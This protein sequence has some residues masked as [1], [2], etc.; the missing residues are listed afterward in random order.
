MP[1]LSTLDLRDATAD[2]AAALCRL[3]QR[4]YGQPRSME[5]WRWRYV[6]GPIGRTALV[7]AFA[8]DG[9]CLAA[10]CGTAVPFRLGDDTVV[11]ILHS[12][13]AVDPGV[14]LGRGRL[15][16]RMA[17]RFFD[18]FGGGDVAIAWGFPMPGLRRVLV[19]HNRC[20]VLQ[21]VHLVVRDVERA[22]QNRSASHGLCAERADPDVFTRHAPGLDALGQL[23]F[24]SPDIVGTRIDARWLQ[25]R[26]ARRPD[27]AYTPWIVRRAD[28]ITGLAITR[29]GGF[30]PDIVSLMEF[31]VAP[32]DH[33]SAAA[34]VDAATR[35]A[36]RL[37]RRHVVAWLPGDRWQHDLQVAH[38]FFAEPTLYQQVTRTWR[39]GLG[40]DRLARTWRRSL[41]DVDFV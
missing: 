9:R 37:G 22:T 16:A 31:L 34:L 35:E 19:R 24:R 20:D 40:R 36:R 18:R 33:A 23:P 27:V 25:W 3:H 21:D 38:G 11:A 41:G 14:G 39:P 5:E 17:A 15:L 7:G 28:R 2:D 8:A 29:D 26:F 32:G 1:D 12:D 6:D 30:D 13:V 10:H 4:A